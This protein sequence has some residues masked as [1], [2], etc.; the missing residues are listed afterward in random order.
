[1]STPDIKEAV[2]EKYGQAARRVQSGTGKACCG[3]RSALETSC[4]PITSNL[5]NAA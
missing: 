1:M 4:D 2:R 3:E 5:Y